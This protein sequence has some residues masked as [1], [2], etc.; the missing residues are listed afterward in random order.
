MIF[1]FKELTP[2]KRGTGMMGSTDTSEGEVTGR[3]SEVVYEIDDDDE[4][5][6]DADV[7]GT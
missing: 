5:E 6:D 1:I 4:D 2:T 7:G 3:K